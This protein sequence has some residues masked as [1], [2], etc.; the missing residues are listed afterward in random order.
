M[1]LSRDWLAQLDGYFTTNWSILWV[2]IGGQSNMVNIDQEKYM[3]HI[4][5]ELDGHNEPVKFSRASLG[6][7]FFDTILD[8]SA[9]GE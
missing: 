2:P 6:N 7:F 5:I 4:V 1:F 8:N 3:K 9:S